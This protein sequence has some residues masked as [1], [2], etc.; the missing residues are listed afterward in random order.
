MP[1]ASSC[2]DEESHRRVSRYRPSALFLMGAAWSPSARLGLGAR[3][4][5]ADDLGFMPRDQAESEC[6]LWYLTSLCG[7]TVFIEAISRLRHRYVSSNAPAGRR[8]RKGVRYR[9][10]PD[11]R[12]LSAARVP[13]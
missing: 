5:G 4:G 2:F 6:S 3:S 1:Q 12:D 9:I 11:Q 10:Q 7:I 13:V 8:R